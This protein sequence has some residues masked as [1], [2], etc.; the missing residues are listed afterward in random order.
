[1]SHDS[2]RSVHDGMD[3]KRLR[4][5][6]GGPA[7]VVATDVCGSDGGES[8]GSDFSFDED[9]SQSFGS[10]GEVGPSRSATSSSDFCR[11]LA[12]CVCGCVSVV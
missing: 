6:E 1:M 3:R 11:L 5:S 12:S 9:G 4:S 2:N 10:D 7:I 8:D